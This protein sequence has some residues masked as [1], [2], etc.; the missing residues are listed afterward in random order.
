M[1]RPEADDPAKCTRPTMNMTPMIDVVFQLIVVF[2]CSMKF[3]TLDQR[4]EASMPADRGIRDAPCQPPSV[5]PVVL[6]RLHRPAAGEPVRVTIQGQRI[7]ST[8]EGEPLWARLEAAVAGFR[9][10]AADL[11][12]EIDASPSVDH[13]DVMR[14]LDGVV[15]AGV[16][17]VRFRGT[18]PPR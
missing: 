15:G 2:L 7:G 17:K 5:K 8:A 14:A 16:G 1:K 10:K 13:G 12:G 9:A 3:R 18:K 11:E 4:I 6:I